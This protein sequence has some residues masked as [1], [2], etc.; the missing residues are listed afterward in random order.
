M[1]DSLSLNQLHTDNALRRQHGYSIRRVDGYFCGVNIILAHGILQIA[2]QT[3]F[4]Y[5]FRKIAENLKPHGLI[6]I[7][8]VRGN[9]NVFDFGVYLL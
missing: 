2:E 5:W 9:N 6:Q 1:N 3:I 4:V 8:R 7:I